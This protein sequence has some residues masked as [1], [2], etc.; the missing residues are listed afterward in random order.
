M[1]ATYLLPNDSETVGVL[2]MLY[3][4]V[5]VRQT[6]D[7]MDPKSASLYGLYVNEENKPVAACVVDKEFAAY[8]GAAL[9]MIPKGGAEDAA[10][11]GEIPQS[12]QENV[13][14]VMN[15]CSRLLM[16]DDTP[17][18]RLA[19]MFPDYAQL[20]EDARQLLEQPVE[21]RAFEVEVPN[22]GKGRM[23]LVVS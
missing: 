3:G 9:S 14:E 21:K 4:D 19:E 15:I 2:S 22:Y 8:A 13:Y 7:T 18:L 20:P 1:K 11:S 12:M 5:S 23:A 6:D 10:E 17:H 16:G